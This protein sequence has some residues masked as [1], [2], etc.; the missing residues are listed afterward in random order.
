MTGNVEEELRERVVRARAESTALAIRGG[1]SKDFYGR[2][3]DGQILSTGR[4]SGIVDYQPTELVITARAG[5]CLQEI[6][7]TL[8]ERN[9]MPGFEPPLFSPA[10]T[11]GGAIATGLAGPR[12]PYA[13]SVSDFVL[14]L[15]ALSGKGEILRF[16][17]Q[18][19]KNVAGFD[20]SRLMV[21]AMGCLGVILEASLRVLPTPPRETT[22]GLEHDRAEE[23]LQ[24]MNTLAR[25]PLPVSAACWVAGVTR[26]RLSGTDAGVDAARR[27]IGGEVDD[28]GDVFWD[29]IRE[30][31]HEFFHGD[32]PLLRGSVAPATP[33]ICP[34]TRQLIDWGGAL[35]W[36]CGAA[37]NREFER[38]VVSYRGHV[39]RFRSADRSGEVFIPLDA[40]NMKYYQR[41]KQAFDPDR[42][43]NPGRMYADL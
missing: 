30:H 23:S 39:T 12:R 6:R 18:V 1:G 38:Q 13:G 16:G 43:L 34:Q 24:F 5:T 26:L 33:M 29:S 10:A 35:R 32:G 37:D 8:A 22:V 15:K 3:P 9:Q 40:V 14:G 25:E 4:H 21:G 28:Q 17:G 11:L 27:R 19:I 20:V 31:S 41:L 2:Q 36:V 7:A 42:A